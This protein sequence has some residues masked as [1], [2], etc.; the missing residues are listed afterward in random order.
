MEIQG[1]VNIAID[2]IHPHPDNPRKDLGD[3]TELAESIKKNG[4][5]QN[6]TVIPGHVAT[7]E[8]WLE[9][10]EKYKAAPDEET[11]KKVND[12]WIDTGYTLIIGHRRHGAAQLAGIAELPCRIVEG[13]AA[14]EQVST[15]LEENMQRNDLTIYEQAQGFQMM[16]NLGET[17]QTIAEK[18]G[19]SK[20]T[21]RHRLNIAKLDQNTLQKRE[22]DESFQLTLKDLL[23]LERVEDV[24]TR[25]KILKEAQSSRDI[26]SKALYAAAE[27]ERAKKTKKIVAMLKP[28]NVEKAPKGAENEQWSG[29][30][31]TVKEISLEKDVPEKISLKETDQLYY[32]PYYRSLRIIKPAKKEK[33]ALTPEEVR[34]KQ[35]DKDIKQ[36]KAKVKEMSAVRREFILNIISGKID[37]LK[38]TAEVQMLLWKVIVNAAGSITKTNLAAVLLGKDYYDNPEEEREAARDKVETFS[39]LH[40]MLLAAQSAVRDLSFTEWNGT[41]RIEHVKTLKIM[42]QALE[43]YGFSFE[44][45]EEDQ[46]LDGTHELYVKPKK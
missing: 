41:C 32:L 28:Y 10:V 46:L 30:W 17:E 16:L 21:I 31:V 35:R 33:K 23:A 9:L 22:Q 20:S 24:K 45:D 6:L 38:D 36:I 13:M 14:K 34:I 7:N 29:K 40:Q 44:G 26:T 43:L 3:L 5:M 42:Y 39:V 1:I 27:A 4:V 19:F 12:R 25:N 2:Q 11:R 8:E 37:P 15:M 18:T